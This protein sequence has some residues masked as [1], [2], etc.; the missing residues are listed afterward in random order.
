MDEFFTSLTENVQWKK[1]EIHIKS[2]WEKYLLDKIIQ[3][4][5]GFCKTFKVNR[6][7]I[8][9]DATH[10]YLSMNKDQFYDM[11]VLMHKEKNNEIIIK[12]IANMKL[13]LSIYSDQVNW[14]I[15]IL[16]TFEKSRLF[17]DQL[18]EK[19]YPAIPHMAAF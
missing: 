5:S 15:D 11:S 4:L 2:G 17:E 10:A 7:G 6:K 8:Q 14:F 1:V 12:A 18:P 19:K 9:T 16:N 3:S 13:G